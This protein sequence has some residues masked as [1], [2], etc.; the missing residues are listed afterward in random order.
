M[1]LSLSKFIISTASMFFLI[2]YFN[3]TFDWF[4]SYQLPTLLLEIN[5]LVEIQ[6]NDKN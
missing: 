2:A 4:A 1:E 3:V 5:V 6:E